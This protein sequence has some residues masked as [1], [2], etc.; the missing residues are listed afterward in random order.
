MMGH[1]RMTKKTLKADAH[2]RAA[3][4][5]IVQ[6]KRKTDV[7]GNQRMTKKILQADARCMRFAGNL[8]N[9]A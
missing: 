3:Q 2:C 6:E 1:R 8:P 9:V 4:E 7:M 5:V